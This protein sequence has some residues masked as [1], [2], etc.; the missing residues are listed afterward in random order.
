[1]NGT[2]FRAL[3]G[4]RA[5]AQPRNIVIIEAADCELTL[6]PRYCPDSIRLKTPSRSSRPSRGQRPSVPSTRCGIPSALTTS[7]SHFLPTAVGH[8]SNIIQTTIPADG[9]L[10]KVLR[11]N[12]LDRKV[13]LWFYLVGL[14]PIRRTNGLRL[15][16]KAH[17]SA[18]NAQVHGSSGYTCSAIRLRH[19]GTAVD[20]Y[21]SSGRKEGS[22]SIDLQQSCTPSQTEMHGAKVFRRI[23]WRREG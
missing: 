16:W 20:R 23:G 9:T 7:T 17:T 12:R 18:P 5:D 1:M 15:G 4:S 10:L 6:L 11:E 8:A 21:G 19:C 13:V 2:V 22:Y 3:S 14:L